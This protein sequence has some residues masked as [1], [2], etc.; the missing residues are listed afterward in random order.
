MIM[1]GGDG[2]RFINYKHVL[3]PHQ[4]TPGTCHSTILSPPTLK[5]YHSKKGVLIQC[6]DLS[7]YFPWMEIMNDTSHRHPYINQP[8]FGIKLW[9]VG[10]GYLTTRRGK[11]VEWYKDE[12]VSEDNSPMDTNQSGYVSQ[13]DTVGPEGL[14]VWRDIIRSEQVQADWLSGQRDWG[15]KVW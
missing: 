9:A 2:M 10:E 15:A 7:L 13:Q 6:K 14:E 4:W 5:C 11:A 3:S 8:S 1:S 12:N